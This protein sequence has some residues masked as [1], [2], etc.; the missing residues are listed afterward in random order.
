MR[1]LDEST[2]VEIKNPDLESGELREALW[3]PPEAYESGR[4][5]DD[6]DYESVLLYHVLTESEKDQRAKQRS[7]EAKRRQIGEWLETAPQSLDDVYEALAELGT[8]VA[9]NR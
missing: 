2:L 6:S 5:L 7:E 8:M 9:A 3:A 1:I 4:V